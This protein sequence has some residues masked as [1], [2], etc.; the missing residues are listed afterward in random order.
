M[1]LVWV[2]GNAGVGKSAVCDAL[3]GRGLPAVDPDWEG[4]CH[5]VDRASR[6]VVVDPPY[7]APAGW[8][9][10]YGWEISRERVAG[11]A[12]RMPRETVFLCGSAENEAEV[13]D[14][15]DRVFCIVVDDET[16]RRR[17]LT[18]T[19]NAFGQNPEELAAALRHNRLAESRYRGLGATIIDGTPPPEEVADAILAAVAAS[20]L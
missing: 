6:E 19:T 1:S 16:L 3:K 17:L 5:W 15:F 11:L 2:T 10:R 14:L 18:R 4:Y 8:L 20:R 13:W 7:P 9:D 12:S